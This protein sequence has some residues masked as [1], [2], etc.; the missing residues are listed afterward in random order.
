MSTLDVYTRF[1]VIHNNGN[2]IMKIKHG[3]L[4]KKK[5]DFNE[6]KAD[7]IY[8]GGNIVM[9]VSEN[10]REDITTISMWNFVEDIE[11]ASE[12]INN[13]RY[14]SSIYDSRNDIFYIICTR[15]HQ[16]LL[17]KFQN[18]KFRVKVIDKKPPIYNLII[19]YNRSYIF[20]TRDNNIVRLNMANYE[21]TLVYNEYSSGELVPNVNK[22]LFMCKSKRGFA[23]FD[24]KDGSLLAIFKADSIVFN[25]K[26]I[27]NIFYIF[28]N[29][30]SEFTFS[31]IDENYKMK[32][33]QKYT[34]RNLSRYAQIADENKIFLYAH[35]TWDIKANKTIWYPEISSVTDLLAEIKLMSQNEYNKSMHLN[36]SH[37]IEDKNS[38][39]PGKIFIALDPDKEDIININKAVN[40]I[41]ML[42]TNIRNLIRKFI[43]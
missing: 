43:V 20:G 38:V 22:S 30:G 18:D 13:G 12:S 36:I 41:R 3:N 42:N 32:E 7:I 27:N 25:I 1:L 21:E 34:V 33:I 16:R 19:S 29:T 14:H 6:D 2:Y 4:I 26:V 28:N 9:L 23:L 39:M 8:L 15:K 24:G 10:N 5:I 40:K 31:Y 35:T 11:I 17:I 37:I